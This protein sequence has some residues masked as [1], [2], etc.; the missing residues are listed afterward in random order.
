MADRVGQQ[1][2]NYQLTKLLG[3][4]AF[5][6]VYLG[7][8]VYLKTLVAIKVLHTRLE[9]IDQEN[10]LVEART[11]A[12][13]EHS[14]IVRVLDFGFDGNIPFL[15]MNYAPNGS[16]R[17]RHPRG[18]QLS[19]ATIVLYVKQVATALQYAH[20]EKLIHRDIKPEN[21]L[22]GRNDEVLLSDFGIAVV[23]QSTRF[24][25]TQEVAGTP[26][27]MAPEQIQ[28]K[29]LRASDQY[30]LGV[31]VYEW[32]CGELP[33]QGGS[34]ALAFQ[35]INNS[36]APLNEKLPD[37]SPDI[38]QVVMT[39]L[40]K[41]PYQRF[42]SV[43]AFSNALEQACQP[44]KPPSV[45]FPP[46][47]IQTNPPDSHECFLCALDPN[48][49]CAVQKLE[50]YII[51]AHEANVKGETVPFVT[52]DLGTELA[53]FSLTHY[54]RKFIKQLIDLGNDLRK[55]KLFLRVYHLPPSIGTTERNGRKLYR[56][57]ANSY[58]LV[59]LE[60]DTV[61]NI[62]DLNHAEYCSRQYLLHR[63][64]SSPQSAAAIRGNLVHHCFKELLKEHDRGELITSRATNGQETP[65]AAMHRHFQHA[66]KRSSIELALANVSPEAITIEVIPHLESL[67]RWYQKQSTTLWDMAA[68]PNLDNHSKEV[69]VVRSENLVRAETFLLAPEI[70]LKGRLDLLWRQTGRQSLL[71]LKTG[72]AKGE[73]PKPDHRWQVYGYHALLTVR[74]DSKM[75]KA[76][77][78]LLYSGT[79]GEAQDFGILFTIKQL[80]RV[81]EER[82]KLVLSHITGIPPAPPGPSRCTKCSMLNQCKQVS[83]LLNWRPPEPDMSVKS[84]I[85]GLS[86]LENDNIQLHG[87]VTT[88]DRKF[89]AKYYDLL[90]M[91]GYEGEKQ[92]ALLWKESIEKR[93]LQGSTIMGLRFKEPEPIDQ[94]DWR[95][96]FSC[97]NESE[98]REGD[99]ILLSNGDPINGE[100]VRGTII[101]VSAEEVEVWTPER[102]SNPTRI[103]Q[104]GT[105]LVHIRTLQNL[106]RWLRVNPHLRGLVAGTFRPRFNTS[107]VPPRM[108]FNVEQNLAVE[109]AMQMQ[110][111]LLIH[112]PPGTG[113]TSVIAEIVK[114]LCQQ[115]QRIMLAAFTN[116]AVDNMLKRL[117]EEGF[118]DYVRLG[119][120]RNVDIKIH[121]RLLKS[122]VEQQ[123]V[124]QSVRELLR[125]MPV[126]AS[127]TASLSSDTYTP[128]SFNELEDNH[129]NSFLQ[130]DVA[131]IDE[132]GQLTVPAI[133]GALRFAK[134]FILVGD[135]KQLPPL[136]LSKEAAEKGLINSL[137]S[138]LKRLDNDYTNH[139]PYAVSSCVSLRIQYRM[140]QPICEF[141]SKT[142]Y[143]GELIPHQSVA[144]NVL[145]PTR[146]KPGSFTETPSITK[147]IDP[148]LPMVF[149][150]VRGDQERVKT[151]NAEARTVHEVVTGLLMRGI[152]PKHIGIIAPYRA[153]VANLRRQLL[154]KTEN[155][156]WKI[157]ASESSQNID[158]TELSI[159]TVDRFQGGERPVIIMSFATTITP[160]VGSRM[161][162]HL[163]DRHRLNVALTRAQRKLILVGCA[164]AL[165]ELPIFQRLLNYCRGL[166]TIISGD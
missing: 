79:P 146:E 53:S 5:A 157:F 45:T 29:P 3:E 125:N 26:A 159:D 48:S 131:I 106:L 104:Y 88:D 124:Q 33:F 32:L 86:G 1:L 35:H 58:T 129:E 134:R 49:P 34:Y 102:I 65:L 85:S 101:S 120:N 71:E 37:L 155:P 135:E 99:E 17:S 62:T 143:E 162:D 44:K 128:S 64:A 72:G 118:H 13:L 76:L 61:L 74:R 150:D 149:L 121:K 59:V 147:A 152:S 10:F 31:V 154:G 27:Y 75:K 163:T 39:A 83:T 21:M 145:E 158:I 16:L 140:N 96:T 41:D 111:Y 82:N 156:Q 109:R 105:D 90:Q 142:F 77:A 137:F 43:Q 95:Y 141:A 92:Q 165:E 123:Q 100:V 130:F 4:G 70:G 56:Y 119:H 47:V 40:S 67:A 151:S 22:L 15:V 164:P 103:D 38:E 73:L 153:Q 166:N 54:Y 98:L 19:L 108:G 42:A 2:G 127:T 18:T 94:S 115:G 81:I 84:S 11:V 24:Q 36:P 132:A 60:P 114:R 52:I 63:L 97:K 107:A 126:V 136:V 116:Q 6:E 139:H 87:T 112:G 69:E 93:V 160:E 8:H 89:F 113:K 148:R 91:E 57:R 66:L 55:S 50:G 46:V 14:N 12:R 23:A 78:T 138:I 133:L 7:E 28:G 68:L 51:S 122:V 117:D 80:H 9:K 25:K 30:V 144:N 110:D 161:R 20:D